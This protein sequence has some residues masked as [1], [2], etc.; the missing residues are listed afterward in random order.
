MKKLQNSILAGFLP[1]VILPAVIIVIACIAVLGRQIDKSSR[2]M[3][4]RS[5]N[6]AEMEL[7]SIGHDLIGIADSIADDESI[8]N[9]TKLRDKEA[10]SD[11]LPRIKTLSG[12]S[13]IKVLTPDGMVLAHGYYTASTQS[14]VH[15]RDII[16][17]VI[18]GA[19]VT[20][21][22]S[23]DTAIVIA[24]F[25]RIRVN[26]KT[27]GVLEVA[28][29]VDY[30]LLTQIKA[31]YGLDAIVYSG[32]FPQATTF[33][34]SA[35]ILDAD[36]KVLADEVK[37]IRRQT[38]KEITLGGARYYVV[39]NPIEFGN[40]LSG[41]LI[42]ASS[43]ENAFRQ[44]TIL[45]IALLGAIAVLVLITVFIS[46]RISL[47][48]VQPIKT[49]CKATQEISDGS[50]SVVVDVKT[51]DEVGV[52]ANAFNKMV[53]ELRIYHNHLND[54]VSEKTMEL[55]KINEELTNE[56][57]VRK[58]TEA[59]LQELNSHLEKRVREKINELRQQEQ[60]LIQQSK[61]AV[62][63][64]M[65]GVIAHQWKQPLN[66][67]AMIIQDLQDAHEFGEFTRSYLADA[68]EKTMAQIMYMSDT[69]DDFRNFLT[70]SKQKKPF[71]INSAIK[72]VIHLLH[73][74]LS[75]A[76]IR[77][78][79]ECIYDTVRRKCNDVEP[80]V[81]TCKSELITEGYPNEFKQV[82]LNI[83]CNARDA[84]VNKRRLN[85]SANSNE[86]GAI[87]IVLSKTDHSVTLEIHDDGG[88]IP[89]EVAE[90]IFAQY[91]TTKGNEG[92]GIG[93]HM[94]RLIIEQNMGGRIFASNDTKGAVFTIVLPS[95][96]A[97]EETQV[98]STQT[99][100]N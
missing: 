15:Y 98:T 51:Q 73:D 50:L 14:Y 63:G 82:I 25:V 19:D 42:F 58:E 13:A 74:Q 59:A 94:A 55:V 64:E 97:G 71:K 5:V 100:I 46:H 91:F 57:S 38:I 66:A 79:V 11:I 4:T 43:M 62:M 32:D 53:E 40:E 22:L 76:G 77:V 48:I 70:P 84:I 49:L 81:C 86:T 92:T 10:L 54:L 88:G 60:M 45:E 33:N 56:V 30:G 20:S 9:T 80:E 68:V 17:R 7:H 83:L 41:V 78:T 90:N 6:G 39:A 12:A 35:I 23:V 96:D 36:L 69:I 8:M 18:N 95:V 2:L 3:L 65:I 72:E 75:R 89:P 47:K 21:M 16:K 24:S 61:M 85:I 37:V 34:D 27:V 93:L 87:L 31:K 67:I 1:L 52:L 26:D 99:A 28:R 44:R 29:S